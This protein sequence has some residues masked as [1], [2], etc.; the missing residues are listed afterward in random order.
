MGNRGTGERVRGSFITH[1]IF[2]TPRILQYLKMKIWFR[3]ISLADNPGM[4][5][6]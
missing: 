4:F 3:T 5:N 1:A 2:V 6:L